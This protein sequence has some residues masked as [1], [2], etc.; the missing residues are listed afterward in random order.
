MNISHFEL[1][2]KNNIRNNVVGLMLM[3]ILWTILL[4]IGII[5]PDES[6][7][8]GGI[9]SIGLVLSIIAGTSLCTILIL[10]DQG[11]IYIKSDGDILIPRP[12]FKRINHSNEIFNIENVKKIYFSNAFNAQFYFLLDNDKIVK[13]GFMQRNFTIFEERLKELYGQRW[14]EI[15]TTDTNKPE[16]NLGLQYFKD[17]N[18]R[19]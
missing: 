18:V 15:F 16:S 11:T 7:V 14:E 13:I 5:N 2:S 17:K 3:S 19:A 9:Y 12:L 1:R 6:F 8:N 10:F 4:Y